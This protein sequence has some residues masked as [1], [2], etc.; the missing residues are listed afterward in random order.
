VEPV[1]FAHP[2]LLIGLALI[3]AALVLYVRRERPPHG[4]A[5][6]RLMASVLRRGAGRRRHAPVREVS[7][8]FAGAGLIL[9]LAGLTTGL[10]RR[11]RLA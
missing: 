1:S 8:G 2:A 10:R 11:S 5:P 4:F 6:A 7:F 3:P 9:L